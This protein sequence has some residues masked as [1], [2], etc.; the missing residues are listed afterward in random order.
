RRRAGLRLPPAGAARR[1][2]RGHDDR[3]SPRRAPRA[4]RVRRGA[5]VP[6]RLLHARD[7]ADREA[8]ARGEPAADRGRGAGGDVREP[9]PL[10]LLRQDHRRGAARGGV[11]LKLVTYE[12]V[13]VRV[14]VSL[15]TGR[16][17]TPASMAT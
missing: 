14:S 12:A 3:G 11:P 2:T 13:A 4:D 8:T 5:R 16:Y 7:G 1:R 17:S 9:V 6:V 15:R 10:R